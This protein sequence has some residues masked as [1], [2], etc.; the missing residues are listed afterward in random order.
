L[1]P[2]LLDQ[3]ARVGAGGTSAWRNPWFYPKAREK[4]AFQ[5]FAGHY[6]QGKAVTFLGRG[7]YLTKELEV[8]ISFTGWFTPAQLRVLGMTEFYRVVSCA[9]FLRGEEAMFWYP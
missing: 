2:A 1:K 8:A 6:S 3:G 7:G 4:R 5:A 9:D